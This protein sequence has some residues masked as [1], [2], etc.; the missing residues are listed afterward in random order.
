MAEG[1]GA[2]W[3]VVWRPPQARFG[4]PFFGDVVSTSRTWLPD[5]YALEE[6]PQETGLG[7]GLVS[8]LGPGVRIR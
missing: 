4:I 1:A 3:R 5:A 7:G 6:L 2:R 8:T